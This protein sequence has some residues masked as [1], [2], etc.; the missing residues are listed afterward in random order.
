MGAG[1]GAA[2]GT[3]AGAAGWPMMLAMLGSSAISGLMQPGAQEM[4][5]FKGQ[6][7]ID[8]S[9]M[10][11]EGKGMFGDVWSAMLDDLA[12]PTELKTTVNPLPGF[13]GGGLPMAIAAPGMDANRL[14]PELRSTPGMNIPRRTLTDATGENRRAQPRLTVGAGSNFNAGPSDGSLQGKDPTSLYTQVGEDQAP[15]GQ[16][17]PS[18]A[19]DILLKHA[20]QR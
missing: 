6:A 20:I 17:D 10:L 1:A 13:K 15:A 4:D 2:A 14:N 11:G 9:V 19:I 5:S 18:A 3:G 8:P 16:G 7:G 12:Q